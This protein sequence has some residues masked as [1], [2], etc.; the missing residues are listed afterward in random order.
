MAGR[1]RS[2]MW[3]LALVSSATRTSLTSR[4]RWS[5]GGWGLQ[6][7]RCDTHRHILP[8]LLG[9][10]CCCTKPPS[11]EMAATPRIT[12][13]SHLSACRIPL[14]GMA[15]PK[16]PSQQPI[17]VTVARAL[18]G[19]PA[20][21][22]G[23]DGGLL[24]QVSLRA[25]GRGLNPSYSPLSLLLWCSKTPGGCPFWTAP[26]SHGRGARQLCIADEVL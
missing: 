18:V 16:P 1:R 5:L 10:C 24:A 3:G 19:V 7:L 25:E 12:P 26:P 23:P 8:L 9:C 2:R 13:R 6:C 4:R 11:H 21:Q 22:T 20:S 17:P 14:L 15:V